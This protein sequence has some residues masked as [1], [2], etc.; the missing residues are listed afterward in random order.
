MQTFYFAAV[1][2]F[3]FFFSFFPRLFSA[4]AKWMST[5][6]PHMMWPQCKFR[7]QVWNVLRAA[8]CKYRT[9]K[10]T[11]KSPSAHHCINLSG[12][13]FATMHISTIGKIV[14][15]QYFLHVSSQYGELRPTNGW[16]WFGSLGHPSKFQRVWRLGFVTTPTSYN[17]SQPNFAWSLAVSWADTLYIHFWGSCLLAEFFQVQNSLSVQVMRSDPIFAALLHGTRVVGVNQTLW[18]GILTR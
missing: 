12:Y 14:K 4:V 1:V 9:Q 7:I 17:G 6:A 8:H 5:I 10:S 15:Q 3:F 18:R 13:I 11:K 16:D 2:T